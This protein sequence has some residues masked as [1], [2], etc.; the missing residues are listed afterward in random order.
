MSRGRGQASLVAFGEWVL[1]SCGPT[2]YSFPHGAVFEFD[3]D[4]RYM[5]AGGHGLAGVG[6]SREMLEGKTIFE[7]YSEETAA[8]IEPHYRAALDG[9][10]TTWDLPY[11]GRSFSQ[12]LGPAPT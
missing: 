3:R 6:L 2:M 9:T 10:S 8:I 5:S 1:G 11:E 7:V 12:R 4:L